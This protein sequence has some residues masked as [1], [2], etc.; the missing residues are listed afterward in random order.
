MQSDKA[1]SDAGLVLHG[2]GLT[3][4]A[5]LCAL[6]A[7]GPYGTGHSVPELERIDST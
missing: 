1:C 2:R 6:H 3:F 4:Y 5:P 7:H